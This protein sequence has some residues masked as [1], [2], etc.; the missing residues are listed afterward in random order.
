M[1]AKADYH[2]HMAHFPGRVRVTWRGQTI[3]DSTNAVKLE[4]SRHNPVYYLPRDDA[5]LQ[6]F[7]RTAHRTHCPHK[8]DASYFTLVS[9][10]GARAE[11]AV[12]S[13]EDPIATSATIKNHLAFYTNEMGADFGIEVIAT[14]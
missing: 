7:H 13:Y 2:L 14:P 3:A 9:D 11:N 4:E 10:D 12:W 1:T 6:M 8:G 5:R